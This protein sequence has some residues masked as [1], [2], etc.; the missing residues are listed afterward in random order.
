MNDRTTALILVERLLFGLVNAQIYGTANARVVGAAGE[1]AAKAVLLCREQGVRSVVI[2]AVENQIVV[3]GRPLLGAS[4]FAR[5]LVTRIQE[6]GAGGLE[7]WADVSGGDVAVLLELLTSRSNASSES[8]VN[9]EL[10]ARR[11]STIRLLPPYANDHGDGRSSGSAGDGDAAE[12]EHS[13][14]LV[15]VHQNVVDL[16]QGATICACQGRDIDLNHVN[17]AV[18]SLV[19]GIERDSAGLFH[20]AHYPDYDFFTFG[21]EIRVGLLAIDV[22]RTMTDDRELLLRVGTAA[23]LHDVGKALVPWDVLHKRGKLDADERL[24]MQRHPVLGA[25]ILLETKSSDPLSVV[26]AYGHH[27][28]ADGGGYP[29]TCKEMHQGMVAKLVKV[30]DVFEAL[31]SSRPYKAAMTPARA[32][33]VMLDGMKGQFDVAMLEHFIRT[34]GIYPAGSEVQLD[35]GSTARVVRQ[36][37]ELHRP[38][39]EMLA[40]EGEGPLAPGERRPCDLSRPETGRAT[41]VVGV[42]SAPI[43]EPT[44]V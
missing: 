7:F 19:D 21:H 43:N 6:R 5:R 31:T 16:L 32:Y 40:D 39:V 42:R 30:C 25:R 10:V 41:M 20:L 15:R 23:L 29:H 12:A 17:S 37:G 33:R 13:G 2:G 34:V 44:L 4:L 26:A 8:E 14:D 22:A 1:A 3:D 27:R 36:T 24:E 35:D 18:E 28:C 9:D 11:V 38:V